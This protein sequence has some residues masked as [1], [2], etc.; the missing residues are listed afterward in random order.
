LR[1]KFQKHLLFKS[2]EAVHV[3]L[4]VLSDNEEEYRVKIKR[5]EEF[6]K[7]R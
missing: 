3:D 7:T 2:I 6:C 4:S 1:K 5:V